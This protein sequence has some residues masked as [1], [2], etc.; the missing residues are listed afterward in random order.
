MPPLCHQSRPISPT[1]F[2]VFYARRPMIGNRVT[3]RQVVTESSIRRRFHVTLMMASWVHHY[4]RRSGGFVAWM[5]NFLDACQFM[6][7]Y[8]SSLL[9]LSTLGSVAFPLV[10]L[11]I[12]THPSPVHPRRFAP[13][14][15]PSS[16]TS[17]PCFLSFYTS[18]SLCSS[19]GAVISYIRT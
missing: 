19:S 5:S 13:I 9:W 14:L 17:C 10:C 6:H 8:V 1:P 7:L 12:L 4:R 3:S 15:S 2:Y 11:R 16:F 18:G